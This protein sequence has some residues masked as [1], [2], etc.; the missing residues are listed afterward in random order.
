M[1]FNDVVKSAF[2]SVSCG[3]STDD[4]VIDDDLNRSF[5]DACRNVVPTATSFECN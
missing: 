5:T 3:R 1:E 2:L 4:V